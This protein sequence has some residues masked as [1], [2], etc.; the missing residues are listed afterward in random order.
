M[1]IALV[2]DI[3][4]NLEALRATL[5]D[6]R[7]AGADRLVCLGD[8]VGYNADPAACI[9][10]LRKAGAACIGGNH[11]RAVAGLRGTEGL[12]A[13]A[14]RAVGWTRARLD[15]DA[16]AFLAGLPG[17]LRPAEGML[18]VHGAPLAAGGCDMTRLDTPERRRDA[19]AILSRRADAPRI[20]A[21]G[22][23][24]RVAIH[25]WERGVERTEA[26]DVAALPGAALHLLN[27]GSVGQPR[28]GARHA[29]WMLLDLARREVVVRRV[30][31]DMAT[32]LAKTRAAGLLPPL[33]LR[34]RARAAVGRGLRRLGLYE[35]VRARLPNA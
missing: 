31:V 25:A 28:D 23:T 12:T 14:T 22:H 3:H 21:F 5:A 30:P 20:C 11:D 15:A 1:R 19:V 7:A 17:E 18:A 32:A 34:R 9:D 26:V 29:S 24:H 8:I 4:A 35:A 10:L 13:D 16:L 33:T 27:P 6:I 2:S